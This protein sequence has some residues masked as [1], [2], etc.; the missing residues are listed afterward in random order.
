MTRQLTL[1]QLKAPHQLATL[2]SMSTFVGDALKL[3]FYK[4]SKMRNSAL[5]VYNHSVNYSCTTWRYTN[6]GGCL[7]KANLEANVAQRCWCRY[8]YTLAGRTVRT[9][10][11]LPDKTRHNSF[12]SLGTI[13][14]SSVVHTNYPEPLQAPLFRNHSRS[15]PYCLLYAVHT[16]LPCSCLSVHLFRVESSRDRANPT[17]QPLG[18]DVPIKFCYRINS[19]FNEPIVAKQKH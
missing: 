1:A 5:R 4:R 6:T 10:P 15:P 2:T 3:R 11:D 7:N 18:I 14:Y 19:V 9:K 17:W 16:R 13:H 8:Q 12:C